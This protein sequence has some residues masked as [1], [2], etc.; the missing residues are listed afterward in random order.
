MNSSNEKYLINIIKY[1]PPIFILLVAIFTSMFI[2]NEHK[3][4]IIEEKRLIET[5][6]ILD[7]KKEI[8][9]WVNSIEQ[10]I[11]DIEKESRKNLKNDL[12]IKIENAYS[13]IE[14]IYTSNKDKKS[15]KEITKLIKDAL[16]NIRF[17]N[18]RGYYFIS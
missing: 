13:I 4:N 15:K 18:G 12:K 2:T 16:K 9:A 1:T 3:K 17:N 5:Q 6:Y 7:E 8:Q 10:F 14:S 11:H